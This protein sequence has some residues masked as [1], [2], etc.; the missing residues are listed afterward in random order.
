MRWLTPTPDGVR[1]SADGG[2]IP[3][4]RS[5]PGNAPTEALGGRWR[6]PPPGVAHQ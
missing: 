2:E 5:P 6:L 3:F 4:R 1:L